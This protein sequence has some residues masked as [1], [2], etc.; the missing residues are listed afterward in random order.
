ML[1]L[2]IAPLLLTAAAAVSTKRQSNSNGC[3][4]LSENVPN[5]IFY[6]GDDVYK[7]EAKQFWSNNEIM[8]PECVFRPSSADEVAQAVQIM[9]DTNTQFAVR[10][11]GHMAIKVRPSL[12]LTYVYD[13]WSRHVAFRLSEMASLKQPLAAKYLSGVYTSHAIHDLRYNTAAS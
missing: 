5:T 2:I 3:D 4:A 11:G 12:I 7:Y 6:R 10:G 8:D 1:S 9:Q 13:T